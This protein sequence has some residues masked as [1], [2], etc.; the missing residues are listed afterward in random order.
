MAPRKKGKEVVITS[1]T[2]INGRCYFRNYTTVA[3]DLIKLMSGDQR[4]RI[5]A[6][7]FGHLLELPYIKQSRPLLDALLSFWDDEGKGFMFGKTLV[8][9]VGSDIALVL[10]LNAT[11]DEVLFHREGT[12]ESDILNH[13][14]DGDHKKATRDLIKNKLVSL[15]GKSGLDDVVDFTKLWVVFL[16]VTILFPTAHYIIPKDLFLYIDDLD[17]IARYNWGY[18]VYSFIRQQIPGLA[19][20]VRMRNM[21]G[22]GSAG[23]MD[24][25]TVALVVSLSLVAV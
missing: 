15:V 20:S 11:G 14:F 2:M 19:Y 21:S 24:G 10:G 25:C 9:F 12:V 17:S 7:P 18:A 4:Q 6:T 22:V 1:S 23:Y 16:F 8:P 5:N 3:E 13:F